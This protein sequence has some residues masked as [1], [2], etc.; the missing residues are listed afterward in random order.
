ML[1][2]KY[3][4]ESKKSYEQKR[5]PFR[6]NFVASNVANLQ[7]EVN[8]FIENQYP[9]DES[10]WILYLVSF[11]YTIIQSKKYKKT[12]KK[13]VGMKRAFPYKA[14]F[15]KYFNKVNPIS[16]QEG[17]G[18]CVIDCLSNHLKVKGK[19]MNRDN[20]IKVFD[21]ASKQLYR[22]PYNKKNGITANM[23]LYLCKQKNISCIGLDQSENVFVKNVSD[24]N[25]SKTYRS[26]VFYMFLTHFYLINDQTTVSHIT[27]KFK[28]NFH[29]TTTITT[30]KHEKEEDKQFYKEIEVP[31]CLKLNP[32]SVVIFN[33]TNLNEQ[34]KQYIELTGDAKP[35]LKYG[36]I[37]GISEIHLPNKI[38]LVTSKCHGEGI[39][40]NDIHTIC[41]END[42]VPKNQSLGE[43][44]L[45]LKDKF[46]KSP[47][48]LFTKQERESISKKS[49]GKCNI[50][51]DTLTNYQI[52]HIR[53]L[54]N[55]GSNDD[56]NLQALCIHCHREKTIQE[57]ENC[58]FVRV[59]EF[60]SC[61][62][63][64]INTLLES[65]FFRKVAFTESLSSEMLSGHNKVFCID[66]N[67][68]R[69]NI[70]INYGYDFCKFSVLDNIEPFDGNISDGLY[71]VE[72]INELPLRG[73][74]FYSRPL[75]EYTLSIKMIQKQDIKYQIKPSKIIPKS[76]FKDFV[77]YL[78][79]VFK[80]NPRLQKNSINY[81]VGLFGRRDTTFY[82]SRICNR[83]DIDDIACHWEELTKPY[84][85]DINDD[86]VSI[87]GEV[88]VK[89]IDSFFPIHLQVLDCEAIELHKIIMMVKEQG[90]LPVCVKTDAVI[91]HRLKA[92]DIDDYYWDEEKTIKKYKHE[93]NF[94]DLQRP[95][96][97][98]HVDK[99]VVNP[100]KYIQY[101]EQDDF[102]LIVDDI[103]KSDK[104]CL[105]LGSAGTGKTTLLNKIID[106]LEGKKL[107]R[108]APTNKS[109]LLINGQT[110]DKFT[111]NFVNCGTNLKMYD[112]I[113]YIFIDEISMVRELFYQ[114]LLTLKN[115]NPK[116]KFIISGDFGQLPPVNEK[117][118]SSYEYSRALYELV[119]GNKLS[120]LK[121]R[122]SDDVLFKLCND[123]RNNIQ[124][125]TTQFG[126]NKTYL[127]ICYTNR[128]RKAVNKDCM[129]RFIQEN[130]GPTQDIKKLAFDK[131]SQDITLMKGM[132][133]IARINQKSIDI[134]NN[135]MFVIDKLLKDTIVIKNEMKEVTIPIDRFNRLFNLGFCIT[136]HKSQGETFN[137][138]YTIYEWKMLDKALKYVAISRS[139]NIN[140]INI[141]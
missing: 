20:L 32:N 122:R 7:Q 31:D 75:V 67:K 85:N 98:N 104:G 45:Q 23:I 57:H 135:E 93:S 107:L 137:T 38:S 29:F 56:T 94:K 3:Y 118:K 115:Y 87:V 11:S 123:V 50:C 36:S 119:D 125:D 105:I 41:K 99:L 10:E 59:N 106:K 24:Q 132:P 134:V 25:K 113:E 102:D 26:I 140:Y 77:N 96:I 28:Q 130:K 33:T 89:K 68:C 79:E 34:F 117:M 116:I 13:D 71:Y 88:K 1:E 124:I 127:N 82:K 101:K 21:D 39:D 109:A 49:D 53:P 44:L 108:L 121:C 55:G 65:K 83:K 4:K 51:G 61:F 63:T 6:W 97:I 62:N 126:N 92:I 52:D 81:L 100:H 54:S 133:I 112:N 90:G 103:V 60:S 35:K 16:L 30:E 5:I 40:F 136:I 120:L 110:L 43:L 70:L 48:K 76:Y 42:I 14:S 138:P 74:Q 80:D 66:V 9:L 91:Y 129:S 12:D 46:F 128:I 22:R 86:I 64:E 37:T 114:I 8:E 58:E 18:E 78:L 27:N 95:V 139:S 15:L 72:C 73:N 19:P 131:N 17:K 69:R 141:I 111:Y 2:S 84:T 47:R